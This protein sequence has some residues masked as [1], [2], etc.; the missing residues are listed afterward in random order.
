MPEL[1][2]LQVFRGNLQKRFAGKTLQSFT[3][4]N[5]KKLNTSE[6]KCKEMLEGQWLKSVKRHGKELYF[7]F[8]NKEVLGVH[9]MLKGQFVEL[10]SDNLS[11]FILELQ[12]EGGKGLAV[13]DSMA[14]ARITLNPKTPTAPDALDYQFNVKYLQ[15]KLQKNPGVPI[16]SFLIDQKIVRGIGNAYVDEIL[17]EAKVSPF[18]HTD[19]LPDSVVRELHRQVKIVLKEGEEKIKILNPDI[20]AGEIRD[21][22]K[23]HHPDKTHSPTGSE[24]LVQKLNKRKTYYTKEQIDYLPVVT[25]PAKK[26]AVKKA[27]AKRATPAKKSVLDDLPF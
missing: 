7:E 24:I 13:A 21:F 11:D 5:P 15:D 8:S 17:W 6:E 1:P 22:M 3:I 23:I 14:L 9:L 19:L 4:Y 2:D 27:V 16:K 18:S 20:I 26:I 25:K 12:F 10:P